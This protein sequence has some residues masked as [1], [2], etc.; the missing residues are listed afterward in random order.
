MKFREQNLDVT[1]HEFERGERG[2]TGEKG[3]ILV[4]DFGSQYT[5]LIARIVRETGVFSE[6]VNYDE[7][8]VGFPKNTGGIIL[9]GSP[10][11]IYSPG[12]PKPNPSIYQAGIPVLGICYGMHVL[13]D[14]HGGEVKEGRKREYGPSLLHHDGTHPLFRDVSS[15][16]TVWMSHG[17]EVEHVPDSFRILGR[18]SDGTIAALADDER[19]LYGL[20]FHPEVMHS[21]EGRKMVA[22]FVRGICNCQRSWSP[23]SFIDQATEEIRERIADG[24]VIC[25][26]SGGVDSTVMTVL[27]HRALGDRTVPIFID[28]GLLR[29]GESEDVVKRFVEKLHIDIRHI[30]ASKTFLDALK[31]VTDPEEKRKTIGRTFIE[32]FEEEAERITGVRYLA[33]GTLYPDLI[34]SRSVKGP[35]AT[36]KSHHNVG[37]LPERMKLELIEPL[38][39]LFKDEVRKVGTELGLADDFI[40]RHPFPGPGLAVRILG[41]VTEAR[42]ALLREADSIMVEEI[43]KA[44]LYDSIWQAFVVL[45]PVQT[46]GVMGDERTYENVAVIRAVESTDGMT[47]H[48]FPIPCEELERISVRITNEVRGINRVCFDITSKPPSTIEWE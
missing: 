1:D 47:A 4:L 45:L 5:H 37:G 13:A 11:S 39:M 32:V 18:S 34:E 40:G 22:N 43:R 19:K 7:S 38:R 35:S 3:T 15:G 16:T 48:W 44:G 41:E 25:G 2:D 21:V 42:L 23:R 46:V 8:P 30:D 6:V 12:S 14:A 17:D 9:S 29:K 36:I 24:K 33:Q 31:G 20:Q 27:I 28:N 26:L 10:S